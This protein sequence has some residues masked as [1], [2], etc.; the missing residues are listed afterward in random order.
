MGGRKGVFQEP[1]PSQTAFPHVPTGILLLV[2]CSE[3]L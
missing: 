2:L 1:G 3:G